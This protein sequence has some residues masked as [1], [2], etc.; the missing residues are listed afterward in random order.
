[1]GGRR[2]SDTQYNAKWLVRVRTNCTRLPA[3]TLPLGCL[4][5][6]GGVSY[7]GYA[8]AGYR[9]K[10]RIVHRKVYEVVNGV[11]LPKTI[12]VCHRCDV[13]N[14]IE[15]THLWA[16]TRKENM[17]D[18]SA[19]GRADRQWMTHC[20]RGH[21]FTPENTYRNAKT[22][23]RNCRAC[24]RERQ[25]NEWHFGKRS[26]GRQRYRQRIRQKQQEAAA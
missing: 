10:T 22:G 1:M 5:W 3:T 9:G 20:H 6:G 14:C 19:K 17:R 21:E 15:E 7:N 11:A 2:L 26:E 13:R 18:C 16:G 4:V 8:H 25:R 24:Q 12:D 23:L